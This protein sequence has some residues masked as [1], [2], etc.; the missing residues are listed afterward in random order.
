MYM[1]SIIYISTRIGVVTVQ[2][3]VSFPTVQLDSYTHMYKRMCVC[4]TY[5]VAI[6]IYIARYNVYIYIIY[7]S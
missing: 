1:S 4:V 2:S 7:I 6:Y 3:S 5:I